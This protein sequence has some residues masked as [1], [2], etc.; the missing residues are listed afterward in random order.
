MTPARPPRVII[1]LSLIIGVSIFK[2]LET[3]PKPPL[4][5][6]LST[7]GFFTFKSKTEVI[8]PPYRAGILALYKSTLE[9]TSGV[10]TEKRPNR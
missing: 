5:L 6:N 1:S 4:N 9:I 3:I 8:L 2:R 10:N 7:Y